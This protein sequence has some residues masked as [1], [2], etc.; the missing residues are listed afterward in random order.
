ML[1]EFGLIRRYFTHAV[2]HTRLSVGDDAALI[3]VPSGM[4]LAVSTDMLVSGT[5]FLPDADARLVGHK[6]LA[7][8]LSDMA[9]MGALPRWVTLSL[10]LPRADADWVRRF[11]RGFMGLAEKHDVDLIGGDTTRGPL[12]LCVQIMGLVPPGRALRRDG[13][14]VGDDVWVS[15]R[16][17]EAAL[18]L[19]VALGKLESATRGARQW[20]KRLDV[21]TP[22]V[23]LGLALR[24]VARSAIDV[25]D[26]L[27]A[28]L[29]HICE[30]SD[31]DATLA[32]EDIPGPV[33]RGGR[34]TT[35]RLQNAV[36]YGGDDYELC[37]TAPRA[38]R[39]A[40]TEAGQRSD[41][42]VTR[43]GA[44]VARRPGRARVTVLLPDGRP[45]K[46]A[47]EG[48]YDHFR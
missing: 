3:D 46:A 40:V 25:S 17:G 8:N 39:T 33:A 5:H 42:A 43:I 36:L 10:S 22:R 18:G 26:G 32:F 13:A 47:A 48:G 30:Q 6:T 37:F 7:V 34:M 15:G 1:S 11:A 16:V 44:I 38:R 2:R 29:G 4:D 28:D 23:S 31:V 12:A 35:S 14:R 21:P 9:A 45:L 41:V 19:A 27:V 20:R 24:G